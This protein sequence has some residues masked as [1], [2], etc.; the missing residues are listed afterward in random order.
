M[1]PSVTNSGS[2]PVRGSLRGV[3]HDEDRSASC[4]PNLSI[5]VMSRSVSIMLN[6]LDSLLRGQ[7]KL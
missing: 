3:C 1:Q 4:E 2:M 7:Y 6:G 5:Q